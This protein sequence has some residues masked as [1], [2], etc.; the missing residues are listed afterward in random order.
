MSARPPAR[1][2]AEFLN[3]QSAFAAHVRDPAGRPAPDGV[4]PERMAIYVELV[5]NNFENFT[6]GAFP[7]LRS[8]YAEPEW[9]ALIREFIVCHRC[10]TPLFHQIAGE[11]LTFLQQRPPEP[12][13]PPFLL[14]LAH[15]EWIELALDSSDAEPP[16]ADAHGDLLAGR[17]LLSPLACNLSY[18]YPVHRIGPDFRPHD[19]DGPPTHLLVYRDGE[20]QVRFVELNPVTARL[21]ECLA[22][23]GD[24]NGEAL[25]RRIA[26]ELQHPDPTVVVAA[27]RELLADLQRRGVIV[28][29]RP[30]P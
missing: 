30:K 17:P 12:A 13:D 20:E 18:R 15:Y 25:L 26:A 6:A 24:E 21:L 9:N 5:Y 16:E 3:R 8:L 2:S 22:E 19:A 14:E 23:E 29:T 4:P 11:F 28:G 10:S 27:G 7:V 1:D